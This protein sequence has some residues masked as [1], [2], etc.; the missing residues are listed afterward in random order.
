MVRAHSLPDMA[1]FITGA[2]KAVFE[3]V[4][5]CPQEAGWWPGCIICS[6]SSW[7]PWSLSTTVTED[8]SI[9]LAFFSRALLFRVCDTRRSHHHV[10]RGINFISAGR[11]RH[12]F[13]YLLGMRLKSNIWK[14]KGPHVH[15]VYW[16]FWSPFFILF[17]FLLHHEIVHYNNGW[18]N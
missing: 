6:L 9:F 5:V 8:L 18:H 4:T 17:I 13:L 15:I 2:S 14:K 16:S 10:H 12:I 11:A 7:S 1:H 3:Q